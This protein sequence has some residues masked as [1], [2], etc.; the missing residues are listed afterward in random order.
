M[1][2]AT[3]AQL[4][5]VITR[6]AVRPS[7]VVDEV[8]DL[9]DEVIA[10]HSQAVQTDER[11]AAGPT[12]NA[13]QVAHELAHDLP[14]HSRIDELTRRLRDLVSVDAAPDARASV[15]ADILR[16]GEILRN[17]DD[18]DSLVADLDAR[19]NDPSY[20]YHHVTLN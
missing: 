9:L 6:R 1:A 19:L 4:A 14:N 20:A 11:G 18:L 10:W 5:V 12:F 7:N 16:L 15:A 3:Y 17:G 8:C 13:Y 2:V